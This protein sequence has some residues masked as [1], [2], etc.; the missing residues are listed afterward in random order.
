MFTGAFGEGGELYF[1][2][3]LKSGWVEFTFWRIIWDAAA[4]VFGAR[5]YFTNR[6]PLFSLPNALS[7]A[8]DHISH[9]L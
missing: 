1:F 7:R 3:Y 4:R 6:Q 5:C 9:A 2:F 8:S